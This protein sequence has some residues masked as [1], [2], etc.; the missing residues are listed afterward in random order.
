MSDD[1]YVSAKELASRMTREE[2][3]LLVAGDGWWATHRIDR[4]GIPSISMTDGPHGVRKGQGA[5]LAKSV[6]ATRFPTA[7]G[8]A[9]SWNAELTRRVGVA[10]GLESQASD[11]QISAGAGCQYERLTPWWSEFR[12]F[13]R[14]SIAGWED[15]RRLHRRSSKPGSGHLS[16]TLCGEQPRV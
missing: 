2:K 3:A 15:G 13:L 11:V 8:P 9:S 7:S 1:Y 14:G 12:V 5:R 4:L 10:L 16:K 6:P